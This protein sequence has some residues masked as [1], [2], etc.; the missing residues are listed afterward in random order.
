MDQEECGE[1]LQSNVMLRGQEAWWGRAGGPAAQQGQPADRITR[2]CVTSRP[3]VPLCLPKEVEPFPQDPS[4]SMVSLNS[5][6]QRG[7]YSKG[8]KHSPRND[9]G[10]RSVPSAWYAGGK[11]EREIR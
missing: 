10:K 6:E 2:L 5:R 7:T 1:G 11:G 9:F 3:S 8:L 4:G